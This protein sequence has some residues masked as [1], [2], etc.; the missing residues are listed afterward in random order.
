MCITCGPEVWVVVGPGGGDRVNAG[1]PDKP[2][3]IVSWLQPS[4]GRLGRP[5]ESLARALVASGQAGSVAYV[6]PVGL[7][8]GQKPTLTVDILDGV[9]V[10]Q[11]HGRPFDA[12]A[13]GRAVVET[14]GLN[15]PLLLNCG[16]SDVNWWFHH[17][18]APWCSRT[19]LVAHD[20][21]HLWP[22]TSPELQMRLARVRHALAHSNDHVFGLSPGAVADL[23][24]AVYVGHGC[25]FG[26]EDP[27]P[28]PPEPADLKA[29]PRPRA[30]YLGALSVI[31]VPALRLLAGT[32]IS[33][34]LLGSAPSPEVSEVARSY[35]NVHLLRP[36]SPLEPT[37]YLRHC[38]VGIVPYIDEPFTRSMEPHN[39]YNYSAAGL[40]SVLLN[41]A[42]PPVFDR[43]V[44]MTC[45][46]GEFVAAVMQAV[47][48]GPLPPSRTEAAR[49]NTWASVARSVLA[50]MSPVRAPKGKQA[51]TPRRERPAAAAL[52]AGGPG[53]LS[54]FK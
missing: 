33:I 48:A 35:G 24:G 46:A 30:L 18:F 20:L 29:V 47:Q 36:R 13:L 44:S 37:P 23:P 22:G 34:V 5:S 43:D 39:V 10:Y 49:Q 27:G 42:C 9:H 53:E 7:R 3:V 40:R 45:T 11:V 1:P 2:D 6:E 38:D 31:D 26:L 16:V 4:Y 54:P 17:V 50:N 28:M 52:V 19:A 12:I 15:E 14:S 41:C 32:G 21:S 51:E 25:D 8:P